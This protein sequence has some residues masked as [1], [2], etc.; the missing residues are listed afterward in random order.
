MEVKA[1]LSRREFTRMNIQEISEYHGMK[2]ADF[3]REVYP[4]KTFIASSE[5]FY[6][7]YLNWCASQTPLGKL[8]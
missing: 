5:H 2:M 7:A 3:I 4:A 1:T 6:K 8:L